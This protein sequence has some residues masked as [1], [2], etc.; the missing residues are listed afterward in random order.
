VLGLVLC[1]PAVG[2]DAPTSRPASRPGI[3]AATNVNG[4]LKSI[5]DKSLV[6]TLRRPEGDVTEKAVS[7]ENRTVR[8]VLDNE[9]AEIGDLKPGMNVS[10]SEFARGANGPPLF[11]FARSPSIRGTIESID[12]TTLT[13]SVDKGEGEPAE[14]VIV[15]TDEKTR[16]IFTPLVINH[17]VLDQGGVR[18]F[19]DLAEKMHVFISPPEGTATKIIATPL[20]PAAGGL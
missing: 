13:V 14:K 5:D 11:I 15:K 3:R 12:G 17:K 19:S 18:K 7:L 20:Q 4:T 2:A 16:V 8:V 9:Y 10:A 6:I 1:L